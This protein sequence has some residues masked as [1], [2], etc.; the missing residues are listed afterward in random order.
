MSEHLR[1][2]LLTGRQGSYQKQGIDSPS[3]PPSN[4]SSNTIFSMMS[5]LII[6]FKSIFH[7]PPSL[8]PYFIFLPYFTTMT[9][10][11]KNKNKTNY[12]YN[13]SQFIRIGFMS[14]DIIVDFV[15]CCSPQHLEQCPAQGSHLIYILEYIHILYNQG[16][17]METYGTFL[18]N[19]G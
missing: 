5:S 1:L 9:M 15:Y 3:L 8:L 13:L 11:G 2:A 6:L 14:T 16:L 18:G 4:L 17:E 19:S 7:V 10:I 12:E